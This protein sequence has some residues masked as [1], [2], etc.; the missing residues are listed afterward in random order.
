MLGVGR[1]LGVKHRLC[2]RCMGEKSAVARR[3]MGW[4]GGRPKPGHGLYPVPDDSMNV[5]YGAQSSNESMQV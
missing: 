2:S 3:D 1:H 4:K 5:P